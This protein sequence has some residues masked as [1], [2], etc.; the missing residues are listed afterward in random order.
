MSLIRYQTPALSAWPSWDPWSTLR[1]E[2]NNLFEGPLCAASTR[3]TQLFKD[4][5]LLSISTRQTMTSS[6]VVELPGM[7]KEDIELSLQDGMLTISGER[8]T[9]TPDADKTA[10]SERFVGKFRGSISATDAC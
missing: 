3:Q 6:P 5:R 1:D 2:M 9:E 7:R 4:G 8:K 10:R